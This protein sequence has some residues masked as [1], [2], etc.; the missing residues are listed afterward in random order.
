[1]GYEIKDKGLHTRLD[2]RNLSREFARFRSKNNTNKNYPVALRRLTVGIVA[3]GGRI[4]E[5]AKAAKV[6]KESIRA[7]QRALLGEIESPRE[8]TLNQEPEVV[9]ISENRELAGLASIYLKS[10]VRIELPV[11][12]LTSSF[13]RSLNQ[14]VTP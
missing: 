3:S 8:L 6:S 12:A 1:M 9:E 13:V 11:S 10:G 4:G 14:G 5:I 7:W 2:L